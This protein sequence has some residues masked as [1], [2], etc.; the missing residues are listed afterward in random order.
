[1]A[2]GD[3]PLSIDIPWPGGLE[4]LLPDLDGSIDVSVAQMKI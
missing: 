1:M 2:V 4:Y 3:C